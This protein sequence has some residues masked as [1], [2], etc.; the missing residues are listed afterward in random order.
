MKTREKIMFVCVL[1][2]MELLAMC[3]SALAA[4]WT[5]PVPVEGVNTQYEE[6]TPFPSFDGHILYFSRLH[7]D[8]FY[9]A[10]I[11]QATR[12][13]TSGPFTQVTEVLHDNDDALDPWV[14][15][16]NLR[17]YYSVEQGSTTVF[18]V[19]TRTS[20]NESWSPGV[21]ISELNMLGSVRTPKLTSDELNIFFTSPNISGGQGSWDIWTASRPDLYSP[22][23]NV[24]NL[25]EINTAFIDDLGSISPDGLKLTTF[26]SQLDG[27]QVLLT[28]MRNTLADPF[29]NVQNLSFFDYSS[30]EW[31]YPALNSD[32][33]VLYFN[34]GGDIYFSCPIPEPATLLLLAFGG[35]FLRKRN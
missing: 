5:T 32:G 30:Y 17:L 28:A 1:A 21:P 11:F 6:W 23:G 22:F 9:E 27:Q 7:T 4:D 25:S 2:A 19:S 20:V 16:D 13:G 12:Q 15:P 35:L 10:R 34:H 33:T 26:K 24:R 31:N 3:G 8:T 29:G 18:K 14:S